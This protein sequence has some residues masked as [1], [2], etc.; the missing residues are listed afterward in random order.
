MTKKIIW[1]SHFYEFDPATNTFVEET[2]D[3]GEEEYYDKE[4]MMEIMSIPNGMMAFPV[5]RKM[6]QTPFGTFDVDDALNPYR[7]FKFWIGHTNF[8]ITEDVADM[9]ESTPGVEVLKI[10]SPLRFI[11]AVGEAFVTKDVHWDI[12]NRLC[13]VDTVKQVE[14][15]INEIKD[16]LQKKYQKWAIYS[17][18]NGNIDYCYEDNDNL[19]EF[20]S[21]LSLYKEAKKMSHGRLITWEDV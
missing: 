4:N 5:A 16:T 8:G 7:Q 17:F 12:Q 11:V 10:L 9:I 13:D 15:K 2:Q 14:C 18:P 21:K 6:M 3:K 1:S 20:N 19:E